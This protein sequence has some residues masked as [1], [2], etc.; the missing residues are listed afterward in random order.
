[1]EKIILM[2]SLILF[3]NACNQ[4]EKKIKNFVD[5]LIE[6]K[7]K[8]SERTSSARRKVMTEA[9]AVNGETPVKKVPDEQH[10]DFNNQPKSEF[11]MLQAHAERFV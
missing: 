3:Y 2:L 8:S 10:P 9:A 4:T 6:S 5:F 11:E 1:M 7:S